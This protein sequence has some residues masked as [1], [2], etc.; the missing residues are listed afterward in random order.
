M[1]ILA[2][3]DIHREFKNPIELDLTDID[4]LCLAG[5]TDISTNSIPWMIEMVDKNPKLHI[6][7]TTGNHEYY[8]RDLDNLEIR[9]NDF[10]KGHDRIHYLQNNNI[11]INGIR[12]I[13][14]TLW[15]DYNN[16]DELAMYIAEQNMNDFRNIRQ[17]SYTQRVL[18]KDFYYRHIDSVR[19]IFNQLH[20]SKEPCVVLT[21]HK[22]FITKDLNWKYK[23]QNPLLT[24]SYE[25]DLSGEFNKLPENKLPKYW[26]YGH[27]HTVRD[28][29]VK[30][31]NGSIDF[32]CN[33]VG[34]YNY[35]FNNYTRKVLE[36]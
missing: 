19:Y 25:S 5:D 16:R 30:Y 12:F 13:G 31:K 6:V 28:D 10:L 23:D 17:K 8:G 4:V 34:Y 21:H 26:I 11:V 9:I 27:N 20:E 32:V 36:I 14:A 7:F 35:E 22:P 3:S 18:P 2:Y 29:K 33:C 15:T 1:K 24:Y